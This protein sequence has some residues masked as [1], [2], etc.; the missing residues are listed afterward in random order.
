MG[1]AT[2]HSLEPCILHI[3]NFFLKKIGDKVLLKAPALERAGKYLD[4]STI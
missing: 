2:L 4:T 3:E 1:P